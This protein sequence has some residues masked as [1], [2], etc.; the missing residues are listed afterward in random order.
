MSRYKYGQNNKTK[1]TNEG[2]FHL[3][4]TYYFSSFYPLE[5]YGQIEF[6]QFKLLNIRKILGA[7]LRFELVKTKEQFFY[8]GWGGLYEYE[9]TDVITL[10]NTQRKFRGSIYF[11]YLFSSNKPTYRQKEFSI[12]LYYQPSLET[13]FD[14]RLQID[15]GLS[16]DLNNSFSLEN[17]LSFRR[18]NHPPPKVNAD[19]IAYLTGI[20][21]QY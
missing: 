5:T 17:T 3:R 6:D 21:F 13:F 12:V 9:K 20:S 18:D 19:N 7:G 15:G 8:F 16:I 1:N 11:S 4:F 10:E 14:Y 2:N